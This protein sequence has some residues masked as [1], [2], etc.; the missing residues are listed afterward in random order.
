M[1]SPRIKTCFI[2]APFAAKTYHIRE[3][4]EHRGVHILGYE[5]VT[6]GATVITSVLDMI[7]RADLFIAVL[8]SDATA[9]RVARDNVL[10]ELGI[11]AGCGKQVLIF[12][13]AK[14]DVL[15]TDLSGMLAVRTSLSNRD[16]IEFALDQVLAAPERRETHRHEELGLKTDRGLG[17]EADAL[18]DR[19]A[20]FEGQSGFALEE[21][22]AS[23]IRA[24]GADVVSESFRENAPID[25]AVWADSFQSSVGNP[26]LIEVKRRLTHKADFKRAVE[27][28]AHAARNAGST[29][30]LLIYGEGPSAADRWTSFP[31]VLVISFRELLE[32]MRTASF[33][34]VVRD[35]RNRRA[36][37]GY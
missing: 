12:A 33:A 30:S 32:A 11:A 35:L 8:T 20:A 18:M 1:T 25:L 22:V 34:E 7:R 37:G 28:L 26:L 17:G 24:S 4:L 10:I 19:F 9:P 6:P 23:A 36:H 16:A 5:D 2:S 27:N 13:P 14:G 15:P 31:T 3:V 21:L 29:W